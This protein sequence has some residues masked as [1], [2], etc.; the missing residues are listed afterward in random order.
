MMGGGDSEESDDD[1]SAELKMLPYN[2]KTRGLFMF[3][4]ELS[5]RQI[6]RRLKNYLREKDIAVS[7]S[8]KW[9]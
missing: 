2:K 8:N 7:R 9:W 3:Y 5:K 1:E 6:F 4:T